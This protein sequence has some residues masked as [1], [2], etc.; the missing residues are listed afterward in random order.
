MVG[1]KVFLSNE[2][3]WSVPI[4]GSTNNAIFY[5]NFK[6]GEWRKED[7]SARY[8]DSW[9]LYLSY[10][11]TNLVNDL[12]GAGYGTPTWNNL[13]TWKGSGVTWADIT[14]FKQRLVLGNT[15][16]HLYY[17]DGDADPDANL[18]GYRIEPVMDFGVPRFKKLFK[19]IWFEFG[20][21][22]DFSITIYHR[23]GDTVGEVTAGSWTSLGTIS[24]NSPDSPSLRNFAKSGRL[25][26]IK[27]GTATNST[28]FQ[29]NR[30]TFKFDVQSEY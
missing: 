23:M 12:I 29:V 3:A 7:K 10:T 26:Q 28:K 15:D 4:G 14:S 8:I 2:I 11:W 6:T 18:D 9:R 22:G 19:E 17:V 27:W 16:G 30:I 5:Y 1:T 25:H 24:C 13:L 21:V 20:A